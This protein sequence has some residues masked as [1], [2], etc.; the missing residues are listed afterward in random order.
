MLAKDVAVSRVE[1]ETGI[2]AEIISSVG[3]TCYEFYSIT[4][5]KPVCNEVSWYLMRAKNDK[6]QINRLQGFKDGKYF[7]CDEAEKTVTYSQD[8]A[9]IRLAYKQYKKLK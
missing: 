6:F 2:D 8:K 7:D 4:R 5:Q 9:L 1:E 3:E